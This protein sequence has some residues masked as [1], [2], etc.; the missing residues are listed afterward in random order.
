MMMVPTNVTSVSTFDPR[1]G[2]ALLSVDRGSRVCGADW[3]PLL[4]WPSLGPNTWV[5]SVRGGLR[6]AISGERVEMRHSSRF[7]R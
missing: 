3:I 1:L 5:D 2:L 7:L 6:R 4:G